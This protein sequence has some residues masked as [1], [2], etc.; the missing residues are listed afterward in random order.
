M[1]LPALVLVHGG[2]HA[3]DCWDLTIDEINRLAPELT[4]L[5]V[6]LPG[7]RG[8]PGDLLNLTTAD[9]VESVVGDI[10]DAG[11][12]DIVLVGH[13]MAGLTVPGVVT[14]LGSSRV[15]ELI[16][17]TA[18]V[19]P[20]GKTLA[21]TLT[22]LF[23]R[24]ARRAATTGKLTP[25]PR[26]MARF[27]F[28]NGMS[29]AQ[30]RF[31]VGKLYLESPRI[32]AENI[33]RRGMPGDVPRTWIMTTRDRALSVKSQRKSIE[34]IGGVQTIIEMDTCH[35]L[36]VSEPER[37]AEILVDRCRENGV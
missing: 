26:A 23:K 9:F 13:S 18:F 22:G 24:I 32:L 8:K 33:S 7:R 17:A 21:D 28:F 20:E 6:D 31:M 16:L 10:E 19:P 25:T 1:A 3:G 37:L 4:V 11:L 29:R 35:D 2:G 27:G 34:A 12:G 5:A 14:K 15:R 30:R 36:M